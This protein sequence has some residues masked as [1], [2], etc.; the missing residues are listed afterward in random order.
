MDLKKL[1]RTVFA[2]TMI[3]I[4]II[5]LIRGSFAAVW[6][7]VPEALPGREALI[8]LCA[9]IAI[10][11]GAGMLVRRT[12]VTAALV[13]LVYFTLWTLAFKVPVIVRHPLV[14]G[15]YQNWGENAVLLAAIWYLYACLTRERQQGS[16]PLTGDAGVR[17]VYIVY[18][19]A[20]LAFGFSHIAYPELTIPLVPK[21]MMWPSFWAYLAAAIYIVTGVAL[22]IGLGARPAAALAAIEITLIT[23]LVWGPMVLTWDMTPGHLGETIESWALTSAAWVL[24]IPIQSRLQPAPI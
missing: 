16:N 10:A 2:L 5:G 14:E 17:A 13:L 11:T 19:L 15:S 12:A 20:L 7:S 3:G 9:F 21:W 8:Y 1:A 24:A 18:G 23:L 6:S 22:V 4:G